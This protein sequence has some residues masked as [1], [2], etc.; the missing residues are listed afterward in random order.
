M[1]NKQ[2]SLYWWHLVQVWSGNRCVD[3]QP[4]PHLHTMTDSAKWQGSSYTQLYCFNSQNNIKMI[5]IEHGFILKF[6]TF[7]SIIVSQTSC[8]HWRQMLVS[9]IY[10]NVCRLSVCVWTFSIMCMFSVHGCVCEICVCICTSVCTFSTC[11]CISLLCVH[12]FSV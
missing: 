12:I 4:K 8:N 5:K 1:V 7:F 11:M 2:P 9:I 6:V 3:S 10:F